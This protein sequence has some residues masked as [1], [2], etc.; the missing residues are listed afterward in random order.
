MDGNVVQFAVNYLKNNHSMNNTWNRISNGE[1]YRYNRESMVINESETKPAALNDGESHRYLFDT[2]QQITG[3]YLLPVISCIGIFGNV[4]NVL[5]FTNSKKYSTNAYLI[6]LSLSDILKLANDFVYFLVN[7]VGKIDQ[8]LGEHLFKSLYLYSHYIFVL[9]AINTAW[10]TCIIAIDR[11][12]TVS[13]R[14]QVKTSEANYFK[15]I[16]ISVIITLL[17]CLIALPSPLFLKSAMMESRNKNALTSGTKFINQHMNI[18]IFLSYVNYVNRKRF[19][20]QI[21]Q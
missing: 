14:N 16:L 15:S 2:A 9:T 8:D 17:S 21:S 3:L 19:E 1:E 11:Y 13:S 10:L 20:Y 7:L 5:V 12:I 6:A 18:I 4:C